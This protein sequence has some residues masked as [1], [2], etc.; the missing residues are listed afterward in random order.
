MDW[1]GSLFHPRRVAWVGGAGVAMAALVL[2]MSQYDTGPTT[3]ALTDSGTRLRGSGASPSGDPAPIVLI[4]PSSATA[5][6]E[7]VLAVV[8]Q[9]FP[10]RDV[11]VLTSAHEAAAIA[12][13]EPRLVVVNLGSGLVTAWAGGKLADEF[14]AVVGST[15]ARFVG[16][17]E[18]ADELLEKSAAAP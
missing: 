12:Q 3:T 9:A 7:D 13:S 11:R 17:I 16:Q 10:G 4:D 18:S 1:L 2:L 6:R 14:P 8:R 5:A 15:T